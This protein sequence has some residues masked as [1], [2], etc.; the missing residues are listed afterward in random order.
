MVSK[1]NRNERGQN[2]L[3]FAVLMIILVAL[4]GLV[5]D[6]GY[7]LTKRRE[8]QNAADAGALAG[9]DA[10]CAG[11][12]SLA[13]TQALDYAINRNG[14][15][16][17]DVT[18]GTKV[19]TVT[20]TIPHQTFLAGIFGTDVVTTT[21]T[22]SAGCYTPCTG[23]GVLPVA[24]AC[25]PPAGEVITDT[26]GIQYAI[27]GDP[28]PPT[29]VIM[30]SNNSSEDFNCQDPITHLPPGYLNCDLNGD[31]LNELATGNDNTGGNRSWLNLDGGSPSS[32][33]LTKWMGS[34]GFGEELQIHTW[35]NGTT[36]NKANAYK[37]AKELIGSI[38]ILPVYN[39]VC[40]FSTPETDCRENYHPQDTTVSGNGPKLY[41]HIITFA[42]FRITCVV[43]P[44]QPKPGCEHP[45]R[46]AA[47]LAYD[48]VFH[49]NHNNVMTIEGYFVPD[50][51]GSGKC[52]GPNAGTYTV[53]LNH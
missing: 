43:S 27:P 19:I 13:R 22:A 6:G 41:F 31:G 46:D 29:Y 1:L 23:T 40:P 38:V 18:F 51:F 39:L 25:S 15:T 14:A 9:A 34:S 17:A 42:A 47:L 7:S 10:L 20:T 16:A 8:A 33:D 12:T 26:C 44:G 35:F 49:G 24:W 5:I 48:Q 36:G 37:A 4:A 53:Y 52:D 30:D 11:N 28:T 3:I 50:Y 21:A 32:N 45:G 2:L